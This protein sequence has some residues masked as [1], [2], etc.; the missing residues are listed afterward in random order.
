M[1]NRERK[2]GFL[3]KIFYNKKFL[4]FLGLVIIIL[5]SVPLAK[6]ISKRYEI[7]REIRGLEEEI[8]E[9]EFKN[10]D[11]KKLINYLESDQFVEEQAR[12]NLGLKKPGEGV[13]VIIDNQDTLNQA[14]NSL[15]SNNGGGT[16]NLGE[17]NNLQR[18]WG[19]FLK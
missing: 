8:K 10:N 9:Q 13:A 1:F 14:S 7:S 11:L 17:I 12:L 18:W 6:N 15:T 5:I 2:N 19:Y 4:A 16:A 3:I